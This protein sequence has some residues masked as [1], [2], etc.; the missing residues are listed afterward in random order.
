MPRIEPRLLKGFRDYLPEVMIPR[1]RMLRK[2]AAVF[3]RF[4]FE[5]LD[6][7]AIE[8]AD[9]LMGKLGPE[10]EKLFYRFR[11]SGD[12]DVALRY[13]LTVSL[14][15][16]VAQYSTDLPRPFKR[17]Q[18]GPVWRAEAPSMERGRF[19]EFW[20]CDV[21]IVGS[22]SLLADA[23]CL[24]V[25]HA[26]MQAVGVKTH[27]IRFNNRKLFRG[28]QEKLGI[29]QDAQMAAIMR[30]VDKFDRVGREGVEKEL[31]ALEGV[32]AAAR[33]TVLAFL[34]LAKFEGGNDARI[35]KLSEFL[36]SAASGHL[37]CSELREVLVEARRMGVPEKHLLVDATIVRGL[38]YYTGT[39]F[40]TTLSDAPSF[41]SVMSGGRYDGLVG[42]FAGKDEPAVGI[43]VGIDRLLAALESASLLMKSKASASVLVTVFDETCLEYALKS[44]T[45]LRRAGVNT[46]VYLEVGAKL[47]KQLAYAERKAIP[48][49]VIAGPEE[50]A[51]GETQL[52]VMGTGEQLRLKLTELPQAAMSRFVEPDPNTAAGRTWDWA[53]KPE[54]IERVP[55][56]G[57]LFLL[58][59]E[60]RV[61]KFAGWAKYGDLRNAIRRSLGP[62]QATKVKT[63]DWYEIREDELSEALCEFVVARL[64]PEFNA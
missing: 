22:H 26:V 54:M 11:D 36:G 49:V 15:R 1:T 64:K 6:T 16:V 4:G 38:D 14:A 33:Q 51:A 9:I 12:R 37:G 55:E 2:V 42:L 44:A 25:D 24:A 21:D 20:Q 39:V 17:Y 59:D 48:L 62:A 18:M 45:E 56:V 35:G 41:G 28:L 50:I 52:R 29:N 19:R 3:E 34:D 31:A 53:F 8:Y 57:G 7:P 30:A 40:E 43:S 60:T 63:F 23:E 47:K 58:R 10:A 13:E 32:D 46:E 5:P 61:V 27:L